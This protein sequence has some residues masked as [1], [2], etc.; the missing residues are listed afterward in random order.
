MNKLTRVT[1]SLRQ[2]FVVVFLAV[3]PLWLGGCRI[4][5]DCEDMNY[6]AF[7]GSWQRTNPSVGRVGSV[8]DPGGAKASSLVSRDTPPKPDA[9]ERE[10][11]DTQGDKLPDPDREDPGAED[12][13]QNQDE[14][15]FDSKA[16]ELRNLELDDIDTDDAGDLQNKTLDQIRLIPG[17]PAPPTIR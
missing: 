2:I 9:L 3:S 4:C 15:D 13:P 1:A 12:E 8:F 6:P 5:A 10:R 17:K 16:D 11:L 7:G 14:R